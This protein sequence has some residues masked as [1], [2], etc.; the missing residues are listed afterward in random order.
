MSAPR[1][2]VFPEPFTVKI[3]LP[4]M[5]PLTVKSPPP[6]GAKFIVTL[7]LLVQALATV[8]SPVLPVPT[9]ELPSNTLE[10]DD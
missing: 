4:V 10:T 2:V 9:A 1:L 5:S 8:I 7:L 3:P 6:P